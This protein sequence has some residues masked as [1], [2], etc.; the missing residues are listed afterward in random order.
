MPQEELSQYRERVFTAAR[1]RTGEPIFNAS[2]HHASIVVEA[3][4]AT[5]HREVAIL[6]GSLSP[7]AYGHYDT[8]SSALGFLA[9]PD[10]KL[11]I[12]LEEGSKDLYQFNPFVRIVGKQPGVA[13]R[14]VPPA[15]VE[16][17]KPH[18]IVAD[19]DSYRYESDREYAAAV[20][21]F[22]DRENGQALGEAFDLLWNVST[23]FLP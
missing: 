23:D 8:L 19:A 14:L 3:L 5:A 18:F 15:F 13:F 9:L 10:R 22:G 16:A 6:T 11:R 7:T 21:I 17:Y 2:A 1:A 20:A 12:L 4:F